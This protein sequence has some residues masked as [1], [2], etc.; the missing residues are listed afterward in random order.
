MKKKTSKSIISIVTIC[1]LLISAFAF[2]LS[3]YIS[4]EF[5]DQ[6][7]D[8]ML[9][10]LVSGM[11]GTSSDVFLSA[12]QSIPL[13]FL[14]LFCMLY[15]PI[16]NNRRTN[17]IIELIIRNREFNF[18]VFPNK[19]L[20]KFRLLYAC[21]ILLLTIM[22]GYYMLGVN[23]YVS[24]LR[25][26]STF[27]D[28]HYINGS[29]ITIAFPEEKRNLIILYLESMEN[30][31][32]T[33]EN[34]GGWSYTVIPELETMAKENVNFSN[35]EKIGG[36]Y[37]VY[38]TTWTVGALVGTTAGIPL[39][40]PVD[41]GNA[42]TSSTTFLAGAYTL[43]DILEKEGYNQMAMFGSD[44][45]F[46]GRKNYYTMH[47]N[48]EMFDLNTAINEGKM[49][50]SEKVWWGFDDSHLLE[51]AKEE[52]TSLANKEK[53]F[54]FTL[55]TANTHFTDG[56]VESGAENLYET[57]YENVFAYSSKQVD[58]F[59]NWLRQQKFFSNTTL[60]IIGDHLSMQ[61]SDYFKKYTY[62]G[63]QRTIYNA[64]INSPVEPIRSKNRV[65]TNLDMFP[66]IL[67]SMGVNIEGE[68]LGLGTNLFSDR[69][70]LEEELG[71]NYV[72]DELAKNSQF[73]NHHIL[74]DDYY[75]LKKQ[76]DEK[77][78]K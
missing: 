45:N 20:Y 1:I 78:E 52:L 64:I 58:E 5:T 4:K 62:D 10:Y 59:V 3:I 41:D 16:L 61:P 57:Q 19:F 33:H 32:I 73:Y 8:E 48:Y 37:S 18:Q 43:G 34:G 26:Y 39:K 74:Q 23:N 60:V 24:S 49:R 36:G 21:V 29:N 50:E 35:S 12:I 46:G 15:M 77:E 22:A 51:W 53:P 30:S 68:R 72:N 65:F 25:D 66:T 76:A 67:G 2:S 6:S 13:T 14:L 69:S 54:S 7:I 42:Y 17:Y 11:E 56:Y 31:M 70:T 71:L 9:F 47:G 63:Y 28:D 55:L 75:K 40:I 44:S 38:G 27:I